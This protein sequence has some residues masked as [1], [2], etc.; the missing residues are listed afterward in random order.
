MKLKFKSVLIALMV[1]LALPVLAETDYLTP[2]NE[3][4]ST[5]LTTVWRLDWPNSVG[6]TEGIRKNQQKQMI[7]IL[8]SLAK[9]NF[10]AVNFQVRGLCDAMYKSKYEPWSE[11][12][13]GTRG[14]D[15]GW[16]PLAFVVEECHKRGMEC[17]AWVNPYRF[18]TDGST[19]EGDIT[20]YYEKGWLIKNPS[21]YRILNPSRE[22]VQNHIVDICRDIIENYDIDGMLFDDYYYVNAT[23]D[24]DAKE[25]ATY[26]AGGGSMSQA[27]WRRQNVYNLM[28]KL[29]TMIQEEKSWIRFGQAP[30]GGTCQ[31]KTRAA[32]YGIDPCPS[33][34]ENCYN[35]QYID[36]ISW[37]KDGI[38]DFVSPQVYWEIGRSDADYGKITPWWG[39]VVNKFNRHLFVSQYA[40]NLGADE[41]LKQTLLNRTSSVNGA[42]GSI[43]YATKPLY[44]TKMAHKLRQQLYS[45]PAL[46]PAMTWKTASNP[47]IVQNLE[48][49]E[50]GILSWKVKTDKEYNRY[51]VYAIPNGLNPDNF[52]KEGKYLI[53]FTYSNT[54][55]IP[56]DFRS[57]YYY[58]VCVYDRFGNEWDAA[59]WKKTY[60]E[61]VASSTLVSP[62]NGSKLDK[63]FN[64]KWNPVEGAEKYALDVASSSDFLEIQKSIQLTSTEI[65][66][67]E[68]YGNI[69]KNKTTYWR[70]RSIAKGKNDGISEVRSF[71]YLLPELTYPVNGAI[72]LDP[73]VNFKW[74]VT[75]E[76]ALVTLEVAS[77]EK[78]EN[79][80]F[81]QSSSTGNYQTP[82]SI[83]K[84]K[85][86]YYARLIYNGNYSSAVSFTTKFISGEVPTFKFPLNGGTCWANS[87]IEINPQEGVEQVII[88]IDSSMEFKGTTRCRKVLE[89]MTFGIAASDVSFGTKKT[90]FVDGTTYYAKASVKYYDESGKL[91]TTDWSD[92]IS[93][94]YNSSTSAIESVAN[95]E[96]V[97]IA[98]DKV[99][100]TAN[101]TVPVKVVAVSMMGCSQVLYDGCSMNEEVSLSE[102]A[103]GIY[104][105]QVVVDG[106]PHAIKYIKK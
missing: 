22:D 95:E 45:L 23:M 97:M 10:N 74:N 34:Y 2:K 82:M 15:P 40:S 92:V 80:I 72:D 12:V 89:N 94:V 9:N 64:F 37:L 102:L 75:T 38:V 59:V 63:T 41:M 90:K 68:V 66:S 17:H 62:E 73:K 52:K 30:P 88:M 43:Y 19:G 49:N 55:S 78:F 79:M 36:V 56:E 8:D 67:D 83:L 14:K 13:S 42:F 29:Y 20:G 104:V 54:Y 71:T 4:R 69:D 91:Q 5:W 1:L 106:K 70:V 53:G 81:T 101:N 50:D 11:Y 96:G 65:S 46:P 105:I 57:G 27:D 76:G 33:G 7:Q 32:S 35:S 60:A 61:T 48:Y 6:S 77:D 58:A 31:D 85:E 24:Q 86:T 93:F 18:S 87:T 47:G 39:T 51:S 21:G 3:F 100:V 98:G 16:D 26:I 25:Y 44:T 84:S 103:T 99:V 28:K